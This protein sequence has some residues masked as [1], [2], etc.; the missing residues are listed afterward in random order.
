MRALTE[1]ELRPAR[2]RM[3]PVFQDPYGSLS[4]RRRIRDTVAEPLKV[5]GRWT[6]DGST[7]V[8]EHLDRVGLDP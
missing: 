8:A 2:P 4:P 6:A 1:R 7:R 3:Q 5:H